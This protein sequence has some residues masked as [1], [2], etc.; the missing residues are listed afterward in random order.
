MVHYAPGMKWDESGWATGDVAALPVGEA[1]SLLAPEASAAIDG[2][3]W[4]HQA[5]TF[6]AARIEL[7]HAKKYPDGAIPDLDAAEI[8]VAHAN[9]NGAPTRVR[10]VTL[11]VARALAVRA[12][13][14]AG[15]RAIGGAG[16]DVL[17]GRTRRVW[18]IATSRVSGDDA[19]APLVVA[20]VAASILL[21]PIVPPEGGAIFGVK[22]A[23]VRLSAAGWRT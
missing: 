2:A 18:Q 19:R 17:V 16:F 3:R 12:A 20:A 9:G 11:P 5:R 8:Y 6:F 23:R 22:G 1:W 21:A 15:S 14:E 10:I 7:V 13:G 4:R